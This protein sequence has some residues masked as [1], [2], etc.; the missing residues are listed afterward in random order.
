MAIRILDDIKEMLPQNADISNISFEG[1]NIV[2][3]T[4][5]KDFFL[6]NNG[7]IQE[8]VSKIK[9]RVELRADPSLTLELEKAE[10]TINNIIKDEAGKLNII[11]DSQRSQVIIEAEKPGIAIGKSG[12]NLKEIKKQTFWVPYVR[13]IPAIKA[14]LITNIRN[15]LYENNDYRKKFLHQVGERIYGPKR[16]NKQTEWVRIA[17]LGASRQVGRSCFLLQTEESNVLIDC[18]IDVAAQGEDQYPYFSAPEFRINELD[19]VVVSHPHLDHCGLVPLLFKYGYKGPI[20][21]TEPT[22]DIAALLCLDLLEIGKKDA[23]N[24]LYSSTEIKEMV[25][26]A[27]TLNF[28]EVTDITPDVRLT[29]YNAGHNLGSAMCHFH[30]GEGLH[31]FLYTGDLNYELSNLLAPAATK[32]PRLETIMIES[33]YGGKEDVL[34][35]RSECE[36]YLL[37]IIKDTI[38]R[39]GKVLLPVLGVGRAQEILV[40]LEKAIREGKLKEVPVFLQGMLW[41]VNAIH[42]TYPDFFAHKIKQSIFH[43]GENPFLAPYFKEIVGRK[44]MTQVLEEKGP[45]VIM[46][47]SGMLTGGASVEY[48][49]NLA[50]NPKNSIVFTSY[51][52]VGTTGRRVQQGEKEIMFQEDNKQMPVKVRLEIYSIHGFTGHSDRN[53][54]MNFIRRLS[55]KPKKVIVIH[56]ESSKTLD[57]ASS[58]HKSERI[59]TTAP[60]N[61]E[62]IRLR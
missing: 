55:P 33:T 56:G 36:S 45:C 21:C 49:K 57:L 11:F 35:T 24:A 29:F 6:D 44:E 8:I 43:K 19:A 30:I 50:D 27:I 37:N 7:L 41:D 13:R 39:G 5:N 42:T 48:F 58:I 62:I 25:K 20:Y 15:V 9:K 26:H 23:K 54:L 17:C 31:N 12:E 2:L 1:A 10:A 14:N 38:E 47:T 4:K 32:F 59:E 52:G 34:A 3:Y 28:E 22:R 18:G 53:Q 16:K 51:L 61:L 46:A 60:K 40:I